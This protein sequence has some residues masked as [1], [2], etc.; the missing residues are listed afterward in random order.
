MQTWNL[1]TMSSSGIT[2]QDFL[3]Y[4][5]ECV[6][7]PAAREPNAARNLYMPAS[8]SLFPTPLHFI[9][10]LVYYVLLARLFMGGCEH[11][12]LPQT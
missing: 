9:S 7:G 11:Q 6:R 8:L 12:G 10:F 4:F 3:P 2:T 1:L 5:E